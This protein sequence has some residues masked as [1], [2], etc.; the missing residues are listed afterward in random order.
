MKTT[1]MKAQRL[2]S[3]PPI[4]LPAAIQRI[5]MEDAQEIERELDRTSAYAAFVS[6]YLREALGTAGCGRREHGDA[7]KSAN[8]TYKKVRKA[9]GYT[10]THT[11]SF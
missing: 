1:Y 2:M 9:L 5:R 3:L 4:D 7:L 8:Q 6:E 11:Y 10:T